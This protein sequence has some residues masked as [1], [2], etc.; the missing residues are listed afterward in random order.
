MIVVSLQPFLWHQGNNRILFCHISQSEGRLPSEIQIN[1]STAAISQKLQIEKVFTSLF[2]HAICPRGGKRT[3]CP[4]LSV[5]WPLWNSETHFIW[6][7]LLIYI[8][9]VIRKIFLI[10]Q[11]VCPH[12][13]VCWWTSMIVFYHRIVDYCSPP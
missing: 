12:R 10:S 4:T 13:L 3:L 8:E 7:F 1:G 5:F 6:L 11:I 9:H 2:F